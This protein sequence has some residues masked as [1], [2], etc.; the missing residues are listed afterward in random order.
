MVNPYL[1]KFLRDVTNKSIEKQFKN[2]YPK[3]LLLNKNIPLNDIVPYYML[4]PFVSLIF[5][6]AGYNFCKLKMITN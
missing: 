1:S 4:L 6:L 5:F 2:Q 3:G